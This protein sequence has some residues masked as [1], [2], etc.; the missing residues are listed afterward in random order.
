VIYQIT[1]ANQQ[2][3]QIQSKPSKHKANKPSKHKGN[4]YFPLQLQESL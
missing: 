3:K 2:A 1:K 4:A